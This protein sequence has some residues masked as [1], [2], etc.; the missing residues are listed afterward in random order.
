MIVTGRARL[1][2]VVGW[3]VG[4]SRSPRLHGYWLEHY[5][6]DGAYVPLPVHPEDLASVLRALPRMGFRGVNLTIP[7]KEAGLALCASVDGAAR[8]IGAVNTVTIDA[9][10]RLIGSNTD[11]FGFVEALGAAV[12]DWK[13]NNGPAV[14]LGA[15]GAARAI[16]VALVDA[17]VEDIRIVNRTRARAE[18]VA[19]LGPGVAGVLDWDDREPALDGARLLVNTTSLGM[20][21]QPPLDLDLSPLHRQA[22]VSDIVYV[23]LITDLLARARAHGHRIVD[24]LGMLMHQARPGFEAWFGRAPAVTDGLRR[25]LLED[26]GN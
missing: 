21:G 12:P 18:A 24:G 20:A 13:G 9:N 5:R 7:H 26:L 14:V 22:I 23:P 8:R 25:A 16:V 6:I 11:G 4:H 19:E 10:G 17:G 15:G 1:A 2:G 3:P